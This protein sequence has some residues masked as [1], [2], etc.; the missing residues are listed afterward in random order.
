MMRTRP[1]LDDSAVFVGILLGI[2]LGGLYAQLRIK[3]RGALRR[4]DLLEFGGASG[5]L[6]MQA[7]LQEAK[8]QA[9]ARDDADS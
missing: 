4:R 2:L 1:K 7:A 8:R 3:R 6:E 5:E 9:R